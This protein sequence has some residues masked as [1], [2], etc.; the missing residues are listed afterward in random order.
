MAPRRRFLTTAFTVT[1]TDTTGGHCDYASYER[2]THARG[3][4][5][6]YFSDELDLQS[7]YA[8]PITLRGSGPDHAFNSADD[9]FTPVDV[10]YDPIQTRR[11]LV[12][13]SIRAVFRIPT[14]TGWKRAFWTLLEN[15]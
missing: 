6:L 12:C 2:E 5:T 1:Q 8:A 10:Q 4:F 3:M 14:P 11:R 7:V 15:R 9:T 13:A